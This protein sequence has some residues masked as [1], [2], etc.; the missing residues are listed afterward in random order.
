MAAVRQAPP[1]RGQEKQGGVEQAAER[2]EETSKLPSSPE[3]TTERAVGNMPIA[4][5]IGESVEGSSFDFRVLDYFTTDR[6]Y[7]NGGLYEEEEAISQLGKFVVVNYSLTNTSAGTISPF[8]NAYLH[9][10]AGSGNV[11][12]Y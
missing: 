8:F 1:S 12:V 2:E 7:Y 11:E 10:R 3:A 6:Y 5:V 9:G 4:G